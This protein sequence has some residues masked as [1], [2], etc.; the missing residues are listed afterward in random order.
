VRCRGTDTLGDPGP[1]EPMSGILQKYWDLLNGFVWDVDLRSLRGPRRFLIQTL[2]FVYVLVRDLWRGD[3]NLRAMSLVYSTLLSVVPLLAVS[4]SMLKGFGVHNQ[5]EPY[6][7]RFLEPLGP[8]G[9]EVGDSIIEFVENIR[10]GVLGAVGLGLLIY[11]VVSLLQKIE[12]AFN[13]VWQIDNLRSLG[14]RFSNYLSVVLIGP[15][16][17]FTALG[18]TASLMS[19]AFYERVV[20]VEPFG[21]LMEGA[22]KLAPYFLVWVAFTFVYVFVPNTRVRL[23]SAAVGGLVAGIAWQTTGWAFAAFVASSARYPAIYSS[24]AILILLLI[25]LYLNWFIIL[26]GA[27][28]SF[29]FQNPQ[30]VTMKPVRLVLSNRLKERLALGVMFLVGHHHYHSREPWNLETLVD[31][32]QLPNEPVHQL[33]LLLLHHGY[34]EETASEPPAY[35]PARALETIQ[36]RDL[37]DSV[38]Q[39]GESRFLQDD[40]AP[41]LEPVDAVVEK[42]KDAVRVALGDLSLRDLILETAEGPVPRITP[43]AGKDLE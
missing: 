26:L 20:A 4:F 24:L 15:V 37:L 16:L 35:L 3:L 23:R 8:K 7:Y 14:Q 43:V 29:Y 17:V 28:I 6:L 10:V 21:S 34:L 39:A 31:H 13:H 19:T 9:V 30:Y 2:R 25:W 11:T 5:F 18:I 12:A 42:A 32:L 38:R 27:Q 33:L 1:A 36:V 41:S 40:R 22:T